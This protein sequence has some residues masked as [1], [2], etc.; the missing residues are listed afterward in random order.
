MNKLTLSAC[1]PE[2]AADE[3]KGVV[4]T[5]GRRR[6]S[7]LKPSSGDHVIANLAKFESKSEDRASHIIKPGDVKNCGSG[8]SLNA[9]VFARRVYDENIHRITEKMTERRI[10]GWKTVSKTLY[11]RLENILHGDPEEFDDDYQSVASVGTVSQVSVAT[12]KSKIRIVEEIKEEAAKKK[13][14][15]IE[16]I[17]KMYGSKKKIE[18]TEPEVLLAKDDPDVTDDDLFLCNLRRDSNG[19]IVGSRGEFISEEMIR[20]QL[21]SAQSER[22]STGASASLTTTVKDSKALEGSTSFRDLFAPKDYDGNVNNVDK[23]DVS[24]ITYETGEEG[25]DSCENLVADEYFPHIPALEQCMPW[26]PMFAKLLK[27]VVMK[28]Y[29]QDAARRDEQPKQGDTGSHNKQ[30]ETSRYTRKPVIAYI[31]EMKKDD[32][33]LRNKLGM[34]YVEISFLGKKSFWLES[35]KDILK[36]RTAVDEQR[37]IEEEQYR[38]ERWKNFLSDSVKSGGKV[39]GRDARVAK[40]MKI[41]YKNNGGDLTRDER[42]EKLLQ[43][44]QENREKYVL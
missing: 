38:L 41:L 10:T 35:K 7:S 20:L 23:E 28:V 21:Q 15:S 42:K 19:E 6:T 30:A 22:A 34:E 5:P 16:D 25:A 36:A 31:N 8:V 24:V 17:K 12:E 2:N 4:A 18:E 43:L 40:P 29:K 1:I 26:E 32:D 9:K 33:V 11:N 14:F 3:V 37:D 27:P 44:L 13:L 39:Y